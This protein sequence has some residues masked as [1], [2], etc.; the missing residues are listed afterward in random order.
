MAIKTKKDISKMIR[1]LRTTIGLT[2]EKFAAKIGVTV[3][4][5]NRWEN[6][7]DKPS[8]LAMLRIEKLQKKINRNK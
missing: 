7:K 5:V 3:S 2:Q 8:P 4:T 6:D 1:K